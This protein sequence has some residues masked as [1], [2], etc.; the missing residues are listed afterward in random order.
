VIVDVI[1][2]LEADAVESRGAAAIFQDRKG[3]EEEGRFWSK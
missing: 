2:N 1:R 3:V